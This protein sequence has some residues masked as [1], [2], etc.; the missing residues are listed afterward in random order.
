MKIKSLV[1]VCTVLSIVFTT[2]L[3][4]APYAAIVIDAKTGEVLHE[5]NAATRLHPA[6]LTKLMTLYAA[7][8]AVETGLIAVDEPIRISKKAA[9]Q[10]KVNLQFTVG[11]RIEFAT[12]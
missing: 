12:S 11:Q 5:E 9:E 2:A 4:A 8:D 7:Y 6:G 3:F 1:A 10:E